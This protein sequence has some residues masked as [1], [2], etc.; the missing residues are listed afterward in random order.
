MAL[1]SKAKAKKV[2]YEFILLTIMEKY[3]WSWTDIQNTPESLLELAIWKL[4]ID[5]KQEQ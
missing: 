2:D 3:W 4:N 1:A 5:N